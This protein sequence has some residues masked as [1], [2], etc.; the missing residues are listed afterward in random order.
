MQWGHHLVLVLPVL[1]WWCEMKSSRSRLSLRLDCSNF[2]RLK[3]S[4]NTL[5]RRRSK[6]VCT[7][8][9]FYDKQTSTAGKHNVVVRTQKVSCQ[10]GVFHFGIHTCK[11]GAVQFGTFHFDAIS[12]WY[13]SVRRNAS[14]ASNTLARFSFLR[15]HC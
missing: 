10:F 7:N 11:F 4:N 13:V 15:L 1:T 12:V 9:T 3:A 6:C 2:C 8:T 14:L 5:L